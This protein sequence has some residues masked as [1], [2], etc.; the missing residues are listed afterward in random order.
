MSQNNMIAF[1]T[2]TQIDET[3]YTSPVELNPA[4]LM[5]MQRTNVANIPCTK[6]TLSFNNDVCV[7]QTPEQIAQLQ[8]ETFSSIMKNVMVTTQK[9]MEEIEEDY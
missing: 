2:L 1:I 5:M 3:G 9:L 6:L 7:T 8:M 4:F